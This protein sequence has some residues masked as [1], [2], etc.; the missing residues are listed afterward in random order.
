M[1]DFWSKRLARQTGAPQPN[2]PSPVVQQQQPWW[3]EEQTPQPAQPQ[4][5]VPQQQAAQGRQYSDAADFLINGTESDVAKIKRPST[6]NGG[7][8][9]KRETCPECGSAN[10]LHFNKNSP[11]GGTFRCF[12]C[13]YPVSQEFSG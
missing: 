9:I 10:Y 7:V 12:D 2:S 8:S 13:G 5:Q 3:Q 4:Q 11:S 1:A 6:A